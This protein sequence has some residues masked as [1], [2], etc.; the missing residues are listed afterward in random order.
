[1]NIKTLQNIL[2][3][4]SINTT[5]IYLHVSEIPL[6]KGFSPLDNWEDMP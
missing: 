3:H 4:A 5:M 2:G 1:M 6:Y